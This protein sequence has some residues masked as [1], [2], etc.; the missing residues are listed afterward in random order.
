[1]Y[2]N[3]EKKEVGRE[4]QSPRKQANEAELVNLVQEYMGFIF[5]LFPFFCMLE[6]FQNKKLKGKYW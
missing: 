5:L 3:P 6:N 4:R 2:I 1:M